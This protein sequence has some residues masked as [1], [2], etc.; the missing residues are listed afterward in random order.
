M[1]SFLIF[2]FDGTGNEPE[3]AK[4]DIKYKAKQEDDNISNVLKLHLMMGGNLFQ[5]SE[6]Y[7]K[8]EL[9][10]I[11]HCF[12]YQGVGTYGSW[13]KRKLNQGLAFESSD[14]A[15]I[16]NR[17]KAD[18]EECY[19][20]GDTVLVT[21]FSRGAALARRFVGIIAK[22]LVDSSVEPFVFLCVFDTV[23]SI[24]LP[25]MSTASRPDY[26]V[27]FEDGFTLSPIVKQATH[28]VSLDDK[29]RAFQPTM[30]NHEPDRI[31]EV[32]F[33]GAHS[34][35]GGGY[36]RDGLSDVTLSYT[37]KWL[38]HMSRTQKMTAIKFFKPNQEA[39]NNACPDS[40]KGMIGIDDLQ[41]NP[42][43]LGKNHQQDRWPV[44][45]WLTLDDRVCC[46][47]E[48]DKI[49]Q[50]ERPII[51][52]SVTERLHRDDDYRPKSLSNK[53]H[54]VWYDFINPP[55][56]CNHYNTHIQYADIN[57][58]RLDQN[59][60]VERVIESDRFYNYTGIIVEPDETYDISVFKDDQ[61]HDGEEI[62]CNGDGW[63]CDNVS[64]SWRELPIRMM[65][66]RRRVPDSDWFTLC[67]TV[68]SDDS[69]A[70]AIGQQG[71]YK[72]ENTGELQLFANDLRS[73]YGNNSGSLRVTIKR[74]ENTNIL[75]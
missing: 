50:D 25:N 69:F 45:D 30:M 54:R 3:D 57:W 60:S 33:A 56:D 65:K 70:K 37:M 21:G 9:D 18:F 52:Y 68:D 38:E 32:W 15:S 46:V 26:D 5:D 61:W 20:P 29:R 58:E 66:K 71:R 47:I 53:P 59:E 49:S 27:I 4:Q 8:S 73:K 51:H 28:M 62:S 64:L 2:N 1:G 42:N 12:Y 11:D 13:I 23:A 75:G 40:L 67:A 35:V 19:Q 63:N 36:Y 14:V 74:V 43:S 72:T 41:R 22:E 34:D 31:I 7:G 24:G 48:K 39:I 16:I 6:S 17:A 44:V 55:I 10:A